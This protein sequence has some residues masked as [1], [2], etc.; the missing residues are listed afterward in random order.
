MS[1]PLSNV[2]FLLLGLAMSY[3]KSVSFQCTLRLEGGSRPILGVGVGME[4]IVE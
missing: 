3:V 2:R 1:C 4:W